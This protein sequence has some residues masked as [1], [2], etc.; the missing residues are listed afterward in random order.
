LFY[1]IY[2]FNNIITIIYIIYFY[3]IIRNFVNNDYINGTIPEAIG[4]LT[5]LK[6]LYI[7]YLI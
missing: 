1:N 2:L 3:I 4:E 6:I 7:Y 5:N